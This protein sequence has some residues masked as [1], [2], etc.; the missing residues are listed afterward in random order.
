MNGVTVVNLREAGST[1]DSMASAYTSPKPVK[2]RK[3]NGGKGK[4]LPLSS[5]KK[6]LRADVP[7]NQ[8]T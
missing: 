7:K 3:V 4:K 2:L 6:T 1:V 5:N 8:I